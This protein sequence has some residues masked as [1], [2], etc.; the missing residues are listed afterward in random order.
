[1]TQTGKELKF[2]KVVTSLETIFGQ[3]STARDKKVYHQDDED[4]EYEEEGDGYEYHDADYEE[5]EEPWEEADEYWYEDADEWEEPVDYAYYT[6]TTI[7]T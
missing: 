2:E 7:A 5:K 1:M 6:D 4:E 3:A